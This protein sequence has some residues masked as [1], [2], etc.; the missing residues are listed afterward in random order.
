LLL[1]ENELD[2]QAYREISEVGSTIARAVNSGNYAE[3]MRRFVNYW[4]GDKAWDALPKPQRASLA[5]LI[6]KVTL[7]FWATLNDPARLGDFKDVATRTLILCGDRS[8]LPS[9]L[10]CRHLARTLPNARTQTMTGA[11][12]MLPMT[13]ADSV[14]ETIVAHID[15]PR[16]PLHI[17]PRSPAARPIERRDF[18]RVAR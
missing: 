4:G 11:G 8:P 12:H 16:P 18:G 5:A 2:A 13:H 9:R 7:E 10:I 3:A 17:V 6:N 1:T 15:A 14:R